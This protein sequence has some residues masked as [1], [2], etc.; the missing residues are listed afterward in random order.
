MQAPPQRGL[1]RR[2]AGLHL[3]RESHRSPNAGHGNTAAHFCVLALCCCVHQQCSQDCQRQRCVTCCP[4]VSSPVDL[5]PDAAV[6]AAR[7]GPGWISGE[8]PMDKLIQAYRDLAVA[9]RLQRPEL[10]MLLKPGRISR[11]V[12]NSVMISGRALAVRPVPDHGERPVP[13]HGCGSDRANSKQ[14]RADARLSTRPLTRA[15]SSRSRK[16]CALPCQPNAGTSAKHQRVYGSGMQSSEKNAREGM[17][18]RHGCCVRSL[19]V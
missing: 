19:R 1:Q 18:W 4:L 11:K 13:D 3:R 15:S 5:H 14:A 2:L 6:N 9:L 12:F 7:A 8:K 10:R 16:C 17:N